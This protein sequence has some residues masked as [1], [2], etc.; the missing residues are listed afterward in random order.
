M[1]ERTFF[2][3]CRG[4]PHPL[5]LLWSLSESS[6]EEF[7]STSIADELVRLFQKHTEHEKK[8][9]IFEVLAPLAENGKV[10]VFVWGR[11]KNPKQASRYLTEWCTMPELPGLMT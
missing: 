9:M 4:E 5:T 1:T 11:K 2:P 7:A 6:K 8:E 3:Y 10:V